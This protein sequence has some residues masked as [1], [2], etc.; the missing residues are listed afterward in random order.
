MTH[1]AHHLTSVD[2]ARTYIDKCVRDALNAADTSPDEITYLNAHGPGTQQCDAAEAEL[3]D[4]VCTATRDLLGE[5][6]RRHCQ[7]AAAA[8]ES[9]RPHWLATASCPRRRCGARSPAA[10]GRAHTARPAG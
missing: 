6:A 1:D 10:A 5:A 4:D 2:P 8:V 3:V 9:R 7:G